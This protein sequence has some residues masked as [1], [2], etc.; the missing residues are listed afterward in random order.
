MFNKS[1][2]LLFECLNMTIS[3]FAFI[4]DAVGVIL[5]KK[6]KVVLE[7]KKG[8][9]VLCLLLILVFTACGTERTEGEID[10][11]R[12]TNM[13]GDYSLTIVANRNEIEDRE[14]F[15]WEVIKKC[16]DN[17]FKTI[18]F[19][20]DV[21]GYA[22]ELDI[23]VYLWEDDIGGTDP[24]MEI[25][26]TPVENMQGYDIVNDVDKFELYIDGELIK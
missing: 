9:L 7:M 15:A 19:S 1:D 3:R 23:D 24:V 5:K 16:Q 17:S 2:D 13:D 25:K 21:N 14:E 11:V 12:S 4:D 6:H 8:A 22:K 18:L 20:T 26:F 10:C